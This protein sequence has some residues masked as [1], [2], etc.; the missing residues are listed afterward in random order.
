MNSQLRLAGEAR[1]KFGPTAD[2]VMG[3]KLM[4]MLGLVNR[5]E[6]ETGET[7]SRQDCVTVGG[8]WWRCISSTP[9]TNVLPEEGAN[10]TTLES[11]R[12]YNPQVTAGYAFVDASDGNDG[13]GIIGDVSRPFL[14][15][16]AAVAA[17]SGSPCHVWLLTDV[18][19]SDYTLNVEQSIELHVYGRV[20]LEL[21]FAAN[22]MV[23]RFYNRGAITITRATGPEPGGWMVEGM[24]L[25]F[26]DFRFAPGAYFF[27]SAVEQSDVGA[28]VIW[29]RCNLKDTLIIGDGMS[30]TA[31][32]GSRG[33]NLSLIWCDAPFWGIHSYPGA[34]DGVDENDT[35][36]PES[37]G[38]T[39][40][41]QYCTTY[42]I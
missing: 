29:K 21:N 6:Y 8:T 32:P 25:L 31:G 33:T 38:G 19:N 15:V 36:W 22:T 39:I 37:D 16:E 4:A 17:F 7:Y 41:N 18:G 28:T 14:T 3:S 11:Y 13:N 23:C 1:H 40:I 42:G 26:E 27:T 5:G 34:S 35:P 24:K 2:I 9:I 10:W 12:I 30:G 20:N